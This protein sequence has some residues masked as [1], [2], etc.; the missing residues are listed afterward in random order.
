[1]SDQLFV[2]TASQMDSMLP[3]L[4]GDA[5]ARTPLVIL[6]A[7]GVAKSAYCRTLPAKYA[8]LLGVDPSE[9]GY[10]EFSAAQR[11]EA[12]VAGYPLPQRPEDAGERWSTHFSTSPL[13]EMIKA[14]G[15]DYG[16]FDES[17]QYLRYSCP[18]PCS[19]SAPAPSDAM[20]S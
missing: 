11:N 20:T 19:R 15:K 10:V 13:F 8:A 16:V 4:W 17:T 5:N 6:G 7:P 12:E 9:V 1:M 3:T 2:S 18:D 14:T